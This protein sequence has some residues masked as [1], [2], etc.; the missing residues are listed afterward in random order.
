[1]GNKQNGFVNGVYKLVSKWKG[2]YLL[3]CYW[4]K[5]FLLLVFVP[6]PLWSPLQ[7]NMRF[8]HE[9]GAALQGRVAQRRSAPGPFMGG[10]W[11]LRAK[12]QQILPPDRWHHL[13]FSSSKSFK[14]WV[15][16]DDCL[17][18]E[19]KEAS[20]EPV[21]RLGFAVP[22]G[23]V[24]LEGRGSAGRGRHQ[25]PHGGFSPC[26]WLGACEL[27]RDLHQQNKQRTTT[28]KKALCG[29]FSLTQCIF[30][31]FKLLFWWYWM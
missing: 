10:E 31:Y 23:V 2:C 19:R 25:A 7:P 17:G 26:S 1:M 28:T 24:V 14:L 13:R 12:S 11:L 15:N 4:L 30:S 6:Q 20:S 18:H 3:L 8:Q 5:I 22:V 16:G 29:S 27:P 21:R 9:D